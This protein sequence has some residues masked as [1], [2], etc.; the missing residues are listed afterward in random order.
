MVIA[1][2]TQDATSVELDAN[3]LYTLD[4]AYVTLA[5]QWFPFSLPFNQPVTEARIYL[6]NLGSSRFEII[7]AFQAAPSAIS[8]RAADAEYLGITRELFQLLT[9]QDFDPNA[10]FS[11]PPLYEQ[12]G[13][14][15]ATTANGTAWT[16]DAGNVPT[17]LSRTGIAYTDLVQLVS[18]RLVNP[19]YPQGPD[20]ALFAKIPLDYTRLTWLVQQNFTTTDQGIND[21]LTAA[22]IAMQDLQAWCGRNYPELGSLL[23]LDNP[24]GG[25]DLAT[26]VLTHLGD[27]G[28]SPAV[29][30]IT[31]VELENLK[32][33]IQLRNCLGWDLADID[34]F[35]VNA[36]G[37]SSITPAR[38]SDLAR[39]QQLTA[40]FPGTATR[41]LL[42]LWGPLDPS[43][44]LYQQL[45]LNPSTLPID[46]AFQP[47][48]DGWV[49]S[50]ATQLISDHIP[51]LLAAFNITATDLALIRAD[52]GLG[53]DTAPLS[54]G[55]AGLPA[56]ANVSALFRYTVLARPL[57]LPVA[58][59]ITLRTLAGPSLDPFSS[60]AATVAF[61][62][63]VDA[64]R[65]SGFS[66]VLLNYLLRHISEPPTGPAP[67]QSTL[68]TLASQLRQGLAAIATQTALAADPTGTL[69][70]A[71]LAQLISKDVA[72]QTTA[73]INGTAIY[74]TPLATLPPAI[75]LHDA[76]G[77]VL[78]IDPNA[79]PA[80]VA[81]KISYDP[82]GTTL[83]FTGAMAT[84]EQNALLGAV[85]DA[86]FQTAVDNLAQQPLGFIASALSGILDPTQA[87]SAVVTSTPSLDGDL[88]PVL[89]DPGGS[90]VTDPTRAAGTAIGAK[91][92]FILSNALPFLSQ[93][94]SRALA[95][96]T[97]VDAFGLDPA[98]A[99]TLLEA[100]LVSPADP[101]QPLVA[102]LL[103]L[104]TP[105]LTA[106]YFPATG[107]DPSGP[108]IHTNVAVPA[109][110]TA[111]R[112]IAALPTV[113]TVPTLGPT[114]PRLPASTTIP[115]G[116]Q[117]ARWQAL[118]LPQVTAG[119]T[120]TIV[121]PG[122]AKL[123]V[124]DDSTPDGLPLSQ[125]PAT[126]TFTSSAISLAAGALTPLRLEVTI[127]PSAQSAGTVAEL[128]WQ[129]P[130][131]AKSIIP[132]A[133]LMPTG[134][135][136]NF[137]L[138]Y[139]RLQKAA[140]LVTTLSLTSAETSYLTTHPADFADLDLNALPLTRD[141]GS[142]VG[143]DQQ[144][145]QLFAWWQ[146]LQ[147]YVALRNSLPGGQV[148]LVDVFAAT[149]IADAQALL[150]QATGWDPGLLGGLL[151][152]FGLANSTANPLSNETWPAT[153]QR[154]VNIAAR[155]G[156]SAAQ[157][158][159]WAAIPPWTDNATE[160][161]G[162]RATAQDIKKAAR[163]RHDAATWLTV[164]KPLSDALRT[165]QRDALVSYVVQ[166]L[167]LNDP[168]QLFEFFLIDAEMGACME[169]SRISQA[170]NSVQL[171][172]QRC[173]MN[174]ESKV[175]PSAIDAATWRQWMSQYSVWGANR[176]IFLYP[177][178]YLVPSL[179]DDI[180]PFFADIQSGVIQ[181]QVTADTTQASLL[182]YLQDLEQVARLDIRGVYWQDT[183][184]DTGE[185]IDTLHVF[186]R[187]FH[188]PRQ[189]FY[190]CLLNATTAQQ[191]TPWKQVPVDIHGDHLVPVVWNRRLRL[192][193][194]EFTEQTLTPGA[195]ATNASAGTVTYASGTAASQP[196][197]Q[198]YW[199]ITLAWSE[200]VQGAWQPKQ[201]SDDFLLLSVAADEPT[202]AAEPSQ[203]AYVFKARVDGDDLVV[204]MFGTAPLVPGQDPLGIP[205]LG[206]FRFT[207]FG[208]AVTVSYT[209]LQGGWP[210][211]VT[212]SPHQV[213][214]LP[215]QGTSQMPAVHIHI[216]AN[217]ALNFNGID[218]QASA[219]DQALDLPGW[220]F[221]GSISDPADT[222][223]LA[224][225]YWWRFLSA[226]PTPFDLRFSH[227]YFQFQ[228]LAP[229]F[230]Q[231]RDRTFFISPAWISNWISGAPYGR[232]AL[233]FS[234]H[235]H[236]YVPELI[237][238]LDRQQGP[239]QAGGVSGLL[240]TAN[241]TLGN[242]YL[243]EPW[244]RADTVSDPVTGPAPMI[245]GDFGQGPDFDFET[246]VLEDNGAAGT[247]NLV[248]YYRSNSQPGAPWVKATDNAISSGATGPASMIQSD[249]K[250]NGHW[251][252][253]VI[254]PEGTG[255][256][257][258]VGQAA[259]A[260]ARPTINWRAAE[261][262]PAGV[263]GPSSLIQS[264]LVKN[265]DGHGRLEL[266][267]LQGTWLNRYWW[268][269]T[270]WQPG[271]API[272]TQAAAPG[273]LI[274]DMR[275]PVVEG[276]VLHIVVP[277]SPTGA[278]PPWELH[279]YTCGEDQSNLGEAPMISTV[280][281]G[282]AS[283]IQSD[284][285]DADI[286]LDVTSLDLQVI[287]PE[288]GSGPPWNLAHYWINPGSDP[289]RT[290]LWD[291]PTRGQII[292]TQASG[293]GSLI[294]SSYGKDAGAAN[295]NFEIL[296]VEGT[297]L[298]HYTHSN[299][300]N[301]QWADVY[302]PG[303]F[304]L[305]VMSG[306]GTP[307]APYAGGVFPSYPV[308]DIDFTPTGAYSV[309]NW[310]LFFHAPMLIATTLSQNQQFAD[311]DT[312]FRYIF[313][314]TND[315]PNDGAPQ[316]YWK[317][318]P[319]KT[320]PAESITDLMTALDQGDASAATQVSDWRAHPFAP[321][322]VARLRLTA[323]QRW[324]FMKYLD[325]LIAW[326]DQLFAQNTRESINQAAQ[327]YVLASD[328]LGPR[329]D[330]APARTATP[331]Q[332][333]AQLQPRLD[334]FS[335]VMELLENEFPFATQV[336]PPDP[337]ADTAG[338]L[339]LS[340]TLYFGIPQNSTMLGYW[341][342]VTDRLTKIRKCMNLQGV[343]EQLPLFQPIANPA[344]LVQ[345]AAAGVDLG[346]VL[347][348]INTPPPNYRFSY[349]LSKALELCADC[350][351]FGAALLAALE[352][353]D[354][355]G[356]ALLRATQETQILNAMETA[357]QDHITE[358]TEAVN[359]LQASRDIT[360]GRYGYYQMLLGVDPGAEP[361]VGTAIQP[362]AV[363]IQA[364]T[365][366]GGIQL[367]A[368]EQSELD[369]SH[370]AG[371][372]QTA[373]GI[374][375][376]LAG[377][378]HA[379]PDFSFDIEPFGIGMNVVFG[380][381][382]LGL[383]T[384]ATARALQTWGS[385]RT[386]DASHASRM[387][388]YFRRWQE[389]ALQSNLASGE[390][391][392]IDHDIA[393]ANLRVS[394]AQE[395]LAVHQ[396]QMANA[397]KIQDT[398]T[399]KYTNQEL[400]Q[401]M[402][403]QA[404]SLYLQLYQMAYSA[405]KQAEQALDNELGLAGTNY[406]QFGYWDSL[407]KGLMSGERLQAG[408]RQLEQAYIT[409]N[410]RE[411]EITRNISL[412]MYSPMALIALK[413]TGQ[414]IVEFP[415]ALFDMDYPG[416]YMRRLKSV[417]LT[418]P[419]VAGPSTSV[420]CT[421]T[422][423]AHKVRISPDL[424]SGSAGGPQ[425]QEAL[426]NDTR[427]Q[428]TFAA[429]ESIATSHAQNDSG[430][431]ELNFRDERYLPFETSGAISRW[432]ISMPP[433]CNAFD[434]STITDVVF[435]LNYTARDGGPLLRQKAF[436]AATLPPGPP[437]QAPGQM[438][439]LPVQQNLGRLF[440]AKHEFPTDW[441]ALLHPTNS[442]T[443]GQMPL[444][445]SMDRLPFRYRGRTI[446]VSG[447]DLYL[448]FKPGSQNN[449]S[450]FDLYMTA[451]TGPPPPPGTTPAPPTPDPLADKVTLSQDALLANVLHGTTKA[452]SGSNTT[453]PN[454]W[455]LSAQ[456]TGASDSL[457]S[458]VGQVDDIFVI[459]HYSVT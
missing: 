374:I 140:L 404:S 244:I 350:R 19:A 325:N 27:T 245:Q 164:A 376:T 363:P 288:G 392:R 389:W 314:P 222:T 227:Q 70:Q 348:D 274:E 151:A 17:F 431:F 158:F 236:P 249:Y 418:I 127:P 253:E 358:L 228:L 311:A 168:N 339:G 160:I 397:Q 347:S 366:D 387:A 157:L 316:R 280:A 208:A 137:A 353:G 277:E 39:I 192:I 326:G 305:D 33:L 49:L 285:T 445:L 159:A 346:S 63:L 195:G 175:S 47:V 169:T 124:G 426:N 58:D 243:G 221:D 321:F 452:S 421:L 259:A 435:R 21:S 149:S 413:E 132:S 415:E 179:R 13:Y 76:N 128:Y 263:V 315:P 401:W 100:T 368:E 295:G 283:L 150:G 443:Y 5:G 419:C 166:A 115:P 308:E 320:T 273:A 398:L 313:D 342:T 64:V 252:F 447:F 457:A 62:D 240:N 335:N 396:K 391:A 304:P 367:I 214:P 109:A 257:H 276:S 410:K 218:Q 272:T 291:A 189:Y 201:V 75:A 234:T 65:A 55:P 289:E 299:S 306:T 196:P 101:T 428:Y 327:L 355:E 233:T 43:G 210:D 223:G 298:V 440:S 433:Q 163:S 242:P 187:T 24:S 220:S 211:D 186:G 365:T 46:P 142:A 294:Q 161:N 126:G 262:L 180:T 171:F 178:N 312:W 297:S 226:I 394:I 260:G 81:N 88:H 250:V 139:T 309:Y 279:Y 114:D 66:P 269:G 41:T 15:S 330:L 111:D 18:T 72:D 11:P 373:V 303:A 300:N 181:N 361:A 230:Y 86:G 183:D 251:Q 83:R 296:V 99:A 424:V 29:S 318:L 455:W 362:Y 430:M 153:L 152:G 275:S 61:A 246:V 284:I 74:T 264:R 255:L 194:P 286:N 182:T 371:E 30:T 449:P 118:L 185:M 293:S 155:T 423:L 290:W 105:G 267:A 110:A 239:S 386:Y 174:L 59:L 14:T 324:V 1:N 3:P 229:F 104:G 271:N 405:A 191:W 441:Y 241:Q 340:Q 113:V 31:A 73:M 16:A 123:W 103:A 380:G 265:A 417:G 133:N 12:Y 130:T 209:Y 395:E 57:A 205:L 459:C 48:A 172:V 40:R 422:L 176:E 23:V 399:G 393:S 52:A 390:I 213:T 354:S 333:Y 38:L 203:S 231:D 402:A 90:V 125:D 26:T 95:K 319:F 146:R 184:P 225:V 6:Q 188:D 71:T 364:T 407:R 453:V 360:W 322:R 442:A 352:K 436:A 412:L 403:G 383:W 216:P 93:Q 197:P 148:S 102:D 432:L 96:Q 384:A 307:G 370:E 377:L 329:P 406:I 45:F 134:I 25:C 429:T 217:A 50:D 434:F 256:V 84:V 437:Q 409:Q 247:Y 68:L 456:A 372:I 438:G 204:D 357:K 129:S 237:K 359:S 165:A 42:A 117:S 107:L 301:F 287:V 144:A 323:F 44:S 112:P 382:G 170:I 141:P 328:L 235:R 375:E 379:L 206:E 98:T 337:N 91:R 369:A 162:L 82:V 138:A 351:A 193:W 80:M 173:L 258:Y 69:T 135:F 248:H 36:P 167:G 454:Y 87:D 97:V 450:S 219:P 416:H 121:S 310:E 343:V 411:Y 338:L 451:P 122:T 154:C 77:D 53:A 400:Y 292:S 302:H 92:T 54:G 4:Q 270:S 2:D 198:K 408:L 425:Y 278:G 317:V 334:A 32:Q 143:I 190:R 427:F 266:L 349:L 385:K 51:A 202:R 388:G 116:N 212:P 332:T 79:L 439:S 331:V 78:G 448:T 356:L 85:S 446:T 20:R 282:A 60:P 344:L 37:V 381:T 281:A 106:E 254:V 336:P 268:D 345:A 458:I 147:A 119:Y 145:I 10:G 261:T 56:T 238:A 136:D 232:Y 89:L 207:A 131:I 200:Y 22:N 378:M 156:A 28:T 7:N 444:L 9:G 108:P 341:A 215:G 34:W 420:N 120:F 414:C 224:P 94:L 199:K 35:I 177:E 67:Q 8:A